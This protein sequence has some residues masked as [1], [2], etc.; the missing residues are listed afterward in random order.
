MTEEAGSNPG[1]TGLDVEV[2][3]ENIDADMSNEQLHVDLCNSQG[4]ENLVMSS[5]SLQDFMANVMKGF[6]TLNSKIQVQNEKLTEALNNKI[7]A[8]ISLLANDITNKFESANKALSNNLIKQVREENERLKAELSE[9]LRS[10][11]QQLKGD[12]TKLRKDAES[13]IE[14]VRTLTEKE[15]GRIDEKITNHIVESKRQMDRM[16]QEVNAK[17]HVLA[18][19][20][21]GHI[22]QTEQEIAHIKGQITSEVKSVSDSVAECRQV[23]LAE[24]QKLNQQIDIIKTKM[25]AGQTGSTHAA[26][27][28]NMQQNQSFRVDTSSSS[29]IGQRSM[30]ADGCVR[31]SGYDGVNVPNIVSVVNANSGMLA[32]CNPLN[33]L[34]IPVYKD[35]S[36]QVVTQFLREL[37]S[38]FQIKGTPENLRLP[39]AIRAIEDQFAQEWISA[40]R[41]KLQ[42]YDEFREQ[43]SKFLWN[44]LRQA[45]VKVSIYQD[46]FDRR[47][48]ESMA[49]HFLRYANLASNLQPPLTDLDLIGAVTSHFSIE[50]QRSLVSANLKSTED[51][52]TF[53]EK[54]QS[55]EEAR[56]AYRSNRQDQ[57]SKESYRNPPRDQRVNGGARNRGDN[58]LNVRYV[59]EN[60]RRERVPS[61]SRNYDYHNT[62]PQHRQ[63]AQSN[64]RNHNNQHSSQQHELDVRAPLFEPR[65]GDGR[66]VEARQI[67]DRSADAHVNQEN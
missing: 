41:H 18:S 11:V 22:T 48:G 5:K 39:L 55:L 57:N 62:R 56:D 54:L 67:A 27:G 29:S 51:T 26:S 35:S 25:A 40:I 12:L 13:E 1:F 23:N 28:S 66:A 17:T 32:Q 30:G 47:S 9:N 8:E 14:V 20:L 10:E 43:F 58:Q 24:I 44:D 49:Q 16:S 46:K 21:A 4:E 42:S 7:Q 31:E 59:R 15:C 61:G 19:D 33:E 63:R 60:N 2:A 3:C 52:V 36:K 34:S 53:L 37:D 65:H 45:Q 6:E 64:G 38:Y 50:I